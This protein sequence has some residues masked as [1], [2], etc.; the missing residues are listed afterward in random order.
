MLIFCTRRDQ[1]ETISLIYVR[2]ETETSLDSEF[3]ARPRRD[4]DET[5]SLGTFS[6]K[7]ETRL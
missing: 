6:L 5:E 1:D 2:D 4:R 7:T 3:Q